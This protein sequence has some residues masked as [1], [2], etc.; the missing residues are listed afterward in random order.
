MSKAKGG[1]VGIKAAANGVK[2]IKKTATPASE[3]AEVAL[4]S[5]AST[6]N[7]E[8]EEEED[9]DVSK[10]GL[11]RLMNALGEDGLSELDKAHL[12]LVTGDAEMEE[13][14]D[15]DV[16][17]A[18]DDLESI[19]GSEGTGEDTE[20]E[21]DASEVDLDAEEFE[22]EDDED[23]DEEEEETP[24]LQ[25]QEQGAAVS[26]KEKDSLA[27]SLARSGLVAEVEEDDVDDDDEDVESDD[28]DD[29]EPVPLESLSE[30]ALAALPESVR[31]TRMYREKINNKGALTRIRHDIALGAES[32]KGALPWIETLVVSYDKS[33]EEELGE[34]KVDA[35]EDD[36]KREV[37]FY[38]Q[39]LYTAIQGRRLAKQNDLPFTRPSDYFAE[40]I[41]SD[42]HMERVRQKLLDERAGLKASEEAKRQRELKKFGKKVQVER[43]LERTKSRKDMEE[44]VKGLKR[45]RKGGL[46]GDDNDEDDFNIQLESAISGKDNKKARTDS[47][48]GDRGSSRGSRGA[49]GGMKRDARDAKYGFGGKKRHAKENTRE[50]TN[51]TT[52]G[53]Y[54]GA[55]RGRGGRGRGGSQSSRGGRGT[56]SRGSKR[57]GSSARPGKARRINGRS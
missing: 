19:E 42:E 52:P 34:Q 27:A 28:D 55:S 4:D 2:T 24:P 38:K 20:E 23:E 47:T 54:R 21:D 15:D 46:D 44:K 9:R 41:K 43:Q 10:K 50:S 30:A 6:S 22:Y 39:A 12:K 14:D 35:A 31:A 13:D 11:M 8:S 57:G 16:S 25:K 1:K 53:I 7:S 51:D 5:D 40:M 18:E 33:I 17:A 32:K 26:K 37:E 48:R 29:A 3:A 49:R 45:K 56:F 36:L